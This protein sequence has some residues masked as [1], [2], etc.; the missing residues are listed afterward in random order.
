MIAI[1]LGQEIDQQLNQPAVLASC[2]EMVRGP[3]TLFVAAKKVGSDE[4]PY[5]S[6]NVLAT[7]TQDLR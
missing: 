5:V 2:F 1:A 6:H 4:Q 3:R 7:Q